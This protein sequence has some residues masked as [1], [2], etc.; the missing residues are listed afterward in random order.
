MA[1]N[2]VRLG[3]GPEVMAGAIGMQR[4]LDFVRATLEDAGSLAPD[5]GVQDGGVIPDELLADHRCFID[6][7]S[8]DAWVQPRDAGTGWLVVIWPT[9][10]CNKE[11]FGGGGEFEVDGESFRVLR[12]QIYE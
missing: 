8:Y 11:S 3:P 6:P 2:A 9:G 5:G 10:W 12:A 4:Y 1:S 7:A